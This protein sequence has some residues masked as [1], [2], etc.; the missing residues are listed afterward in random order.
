MDDNNREA[1]KKEVDDWIA[2]PGRY[3]AGV[4][5]GIIALA[6][7]W[8]TVRESFWMAVVIVVGA[9]AF[10]FFTQMDD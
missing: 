9:A 7:A 1:E 10:Y 6:F 5:I 8:S 2:G 3:F 4:I